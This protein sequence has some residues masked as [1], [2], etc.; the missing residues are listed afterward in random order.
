MR[1]GKEVGTIDIH[2]DPKSL[3]SD[4]S[5]A[6]KKTFRELV[7]RMAKG[8]A[9]ER[10][11][12]LLEKLTI[13]RIEQVQKPQISGVADKFQVGTW[14]ADKLCSNSERIAQNGPTRI[15]VYDMSDVVRRTVEQFDGIPFHKDR[16][17]L[18]TRK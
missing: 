12:R 8:Y 5:E 4:H 18:A 16:P 14:V 1:T 6:L 17:I 9:Y 15:S 3:K 13:R 7:V 11:S 2:F 10:G